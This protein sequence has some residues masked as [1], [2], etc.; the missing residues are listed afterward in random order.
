MDGPAARIVTIHPTFTTIDVPG[1]VYTQALAINTSGDIVG[2][3]GQDSAS[4]SAGFLAR[5]GAFTYFGYPG[6]AVTV[7]LGINDFGVIVGHAGQFPVLGFLYDGIKFTTLQDGADT[8]TFASGINN[9]G[10]VVGGAGTIYTTK[11]FMMRNGQYRTINFP[12]NYIYAQAEAINNLG[13][14]AADGDNCGYAIKNGKFRQVAVAGAIQT[15]A[16]GINDS[17]TIVGWYNL[18][19]S[20]DYAFVLMKGTYLSFAYP[21]AIATF[22]AGINN[23][24]QVVGSYTLDYQTYHGFVT[25][26]ITS[27]ELQ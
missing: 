6:Q 13:E 11:G 8:A 7:P 19:S 21:G 1:A 18:G 27:A 24:G 12:D 23:A 17:G 4:D 2:N 25:D 20:N 15:D 5:N 10:I 9:N 22:A 3:Y 14:I 26:P 16:L